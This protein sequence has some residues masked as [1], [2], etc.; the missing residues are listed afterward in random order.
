MLMDFTSIVTIVPSFIGVV[1]VL[2]AIH[3]G[4]HFLM[5]RLVG[6]PVEVFSIGFGKRL[7][8]F[9]RGETDYRISVV[10]LGGY[11]RIPGLGPDESDVVGIESDARELLPRFKRALILLAGPLTN[12]VAAVL[13]ISF[14]FIIGAQV[15]AYLRQPPVVGWVDPDSA[16]ASA[17]FEAGDRVLTVDRTSVKTWRDLEM[18]LS[19]AEGH[20]LEVELDRSGSVLTRTMAPDKQPRYGFGHSGLQPEFDSTVVSMPLGSPAAAAG[21]KKGDRIVAIDGEPVSQFYD[22]IRL[23]SPRPGETLDVT[24]LRGSEKL[25]RTVVADN[26]DGV[27]KIGISMRLPSEL[28]KLGPAAALAAGWEECLRVTRLTFQVIGRLLTRR[29]SVA[30]MAGP[31]GIAQLSGEAARGGIRT[32]IWFTGVISLNLGIFNLLPIPILDGGHLTVLGLETAIRRDFSIRVKERIMEVGFYL[33]I[34][35]F[36]VVSYNDIIRMFFKGK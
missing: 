20:P 13:F 22:I 10:P 30:N 9:R 18:A 28:I 3:E 34:L 26:Y 19:V 2:I 5:A 23:V 21:I 6:A 16:A 31:L 33:L 32:L 4:G 15:D 8:G 35:L 29:A 25:T 11:V 1:G 36:I 12:V 14:V 24:V 7:W 17:G 27:G